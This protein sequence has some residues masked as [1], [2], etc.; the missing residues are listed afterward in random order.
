MKP[1][2][3]FILVFVCS[4][5]GCK[6][7]VTIDPPDNQIV[8]P[9]PFTSDATATST[10]TG[11][12]SE[13]MNGQSQFSSAFTTLYPG[14]YADELYYYT[15]GPRDE[16]V[17]SSLT[18][19]S[20][21]LI[22]SAFWSPMYKYIYAANLTLEQLR[23]STLLSADVKLQLTGEALFIRAFCYSYLVDL[24]GDVPLVLSSAYT[25]NMSLPRK[26]KAA[27][28]EQIN[29]DLMDAAG[30]LTDNYP[31]AGRVRPNKFTAKALLARMYLYEKNY[32]KAKQT[33][34]EMIASN[35]YHLE[36]DPS[37]VF[38]KDSKEAIWQL[39]PVKPNLNTTEANL[40]IPA[41]SSSQPTYLVTSYLLN[42]FEIGDKRKVAWINS[43]T[44]SGKQ[45]YYPYKYKVRSSA[46]LSEYYNVFRLAEQYLIRAEASAHLNNLDAAKEDINIIRSRAGLSPVTATDQPSIVAAIAQERRIELCFEWGHRW[47]DLQR[48]GRATAVLEGIKPG[49]KETDTLWPVPINQINLNPALVQNLGY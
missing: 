43:R 9:A 30:L 22:N 42:A 21:G 6:K 24:F 48:T 3:I 47:F 1:I 32:N 7:F 26:D 33:A 45:L 4:I 8:N 12:Y 5:G 35:L 20:H 14:M 29:S 49:W 23:L 13:M 37:S 19:S 44:Y 36:T 34:D 41:S 15:P 40:I 10:I 31:T 25:S 39:Q 2:I 17:A 38:L 18:A 11:I 27:V 46:T 28:Y 16:F